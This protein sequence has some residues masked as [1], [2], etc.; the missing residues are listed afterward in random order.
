MRIE[1]T[2]EEADPK[3]ADPDVFDRPLIILMDGLHHQFHEDG[4]LTPQL[5]KVDIGTI[6]R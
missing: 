6:A 2:Q 3:L 1:P 4:R 5:L